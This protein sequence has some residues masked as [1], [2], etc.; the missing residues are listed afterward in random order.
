MCIHTF[1]FLKIVT[2]ISGKK[3]RDFPH[4]HP[5]WNGLLDA[6]TTEIIGKDMNLINEL[7]EW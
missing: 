1:N 5:V 2:T 7:D 4:S 3:W 6:T